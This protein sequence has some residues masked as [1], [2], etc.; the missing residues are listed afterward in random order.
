MGRAKTSHL[1]TMTKYTAIVKP[2]SKAKRRKLATKKAPTITYTKT[3][4]VLVCLVATMLITT[5]FQNFW[6][7][8]YTIA[9]PPR[10]YQDIS[11]DPTPYLP[12]IQP[13]QENW[14]SPY[15]QFK[16]PLLKYLE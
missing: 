1:T 16:S 15:N 2:I 4:I 5:L 8:S 9:T 14:L 10:H 3:N 13:Q 12:K 6:T 11:Y 7:P